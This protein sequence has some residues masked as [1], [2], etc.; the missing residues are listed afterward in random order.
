MDVPM[1]GLERDFGR[2]KLNKQ[3]TAAQLQIAQRMQQY[4]NMIDKNDL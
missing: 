4:E 2:L 3:P 1:I